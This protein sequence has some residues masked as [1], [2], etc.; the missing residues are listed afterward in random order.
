MKMINV[1]LNNQKEVMFEVRISPKIFVYINNDQK[2]ILM[3]P[4]SN[5]LQSAL[6]PCVWKNM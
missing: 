3:T 2:S 4:K 5:P 6:L 1:Y